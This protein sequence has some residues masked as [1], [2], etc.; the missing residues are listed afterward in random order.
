MQ[1]EA[2][3]PRYAGSVRGERY[4]SHTGGG[5]GV[6]LIKKLN[7]E[8]RLHFWG[9]HLNF[10]SGARG[11]SCTSCKGP[12][13]RG[14]LRVFDGGAIRFNVRMQGCPPMTG[15]YTGSPQKNIIT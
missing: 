4:P 8:L 3:C 10:L 11:T 6:S 14:A 9:L 13:L 15:R 1:E 2:V 12:N 7:L 5:M